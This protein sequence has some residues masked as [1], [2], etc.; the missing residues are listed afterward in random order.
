MAILDKFCLYF[1]V[2]NL[3]KHLKNLCSTSDLISF[4]LSLSQSVEI[5][6]TV[7]QVVRDSSHTFGSRI[8]MILIVQIF[9]FLPFC[10]SRCAQATCKLWFQALHSSIAKK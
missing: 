8:P 3:Q 1:Y 2:E 4:L 5:L 7:S 10:E 9:S 6:H